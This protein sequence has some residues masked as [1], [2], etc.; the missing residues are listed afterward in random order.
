MAYTASS[1]DGSEDGVFVVNT[2]NGTV[3]P[4]MSGEGIYKKLA[5]DKAG[6]QLAF[7]SNSDDY[8]SD[9]P[10]F[11][12]YHWIPDSEGANLLAEASSEGL[13]EGWWISEHG[14]LSFSENGNRLL[15]GTAPRPA[16][17]KE[18]EIPDDEEVELD[19]WHWQDPFLQPMQLVQLEDEEK[20]S[21]LALVHL[22]D[23]HIVQLADEFI[24]EVTIGSKGEADIAIGNSNIPYRLLISWESPAFYDIYT[25]DVP[26]R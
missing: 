8:E 2:S 10:A 21:Y 26:H 12:L 24:P 17:E 6:S 4:V 1:K 19:I 25:I 13:P 23:R 16:E 11:A 15:F 22:E 9:Q 7:L 20:R 3:T 14:K 5:F 18:D